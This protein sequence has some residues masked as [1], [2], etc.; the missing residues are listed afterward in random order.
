MRDPLTWQDVWLVGLGSAL[1]G[2]VL[3]G[4]VARLTVYWTQRGDR[5]AAKLVESQRAAEAL[6]R[7]AAATFNAIG[8]AKAGDDLDLHPWHTELIAQLPVLQ[9]QEVGSR[10][11]MLNNEWTDFAM[12]LRVQK[13]REW[14]QVD[15]ATGDLLLDANTGWPISS[16]D[17]RH[18]ALIA[19]K[20]KLGQRHIWVGRSLAAHRMGAPLPAIGELPSL[21][22][23]PAAS[24]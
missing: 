8:Q 1:A 9:D 4:I 2:G 3:A 12:W 7:A 14:Y 17:D 23:L 19:Y 10:V 6:T 11:N 13:P 24:D 22:E 16:D 20:T 5:A 21:P 18:K 15:P